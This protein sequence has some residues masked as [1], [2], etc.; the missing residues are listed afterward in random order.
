MAHSEGKGGKDKG[1]LHEVAFEQRRAGTHLDLLK[2]SKSLSLLPHLHIE[3]IMA[4][5]L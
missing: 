4:G 3:G 5:D 2:I 1:M